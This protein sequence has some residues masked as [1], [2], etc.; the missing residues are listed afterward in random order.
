M[1][2]YTPLQRVA[3]SDD[4]DIEQ[5]PPRYADAKL[6]GQLF[7]KPRQNIGLHAD[8][9]FDE[10]PLAP[11]A[12]EHAPGSPEKMLVMQWRLANGYRAF[13]PA[14]A[15]VISRIPH[16]SARGCEID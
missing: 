3:Q 11:E 13:H 6:E 14:D 16:G 10:P 8:G 2:A 9:G 4:S 5:L 1:I 12:T 7:R 15:A